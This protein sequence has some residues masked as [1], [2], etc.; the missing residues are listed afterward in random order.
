[1]LV[2]FA[3]GSGAA[4]AGVG[5]A[6]WAACRLGEGFAD[7]SGLGAVS[8]SNSASARLVSGVRDR[9]E[10]PVVTGTA[11]V[12]LT[13]A[14]V[15]VG[16]AAAA[17]ARA[18]LVLSRRVRVGVACTLLVLGLGT[19]TP[20]VPALTSSCCR[21][22]ASVSTLTPGTFEVAGAV[23]GW[24]CLAGSRSLSFDVVGAAGGS[25]VDVAA[26]SF[27]RIFVPPP[28]PLLSSSGAG[29]VFLV[30]AIRVFMNFSSS[31][32]RMAMSLSSSL[33]IRALV[34]RWL[35]SSMNAFHDLN[36]WGAL[37]FEVVGFLRSVPRTAR[38][39][40]RSETG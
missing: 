30:S 39:I 5:V 29:T 11:P 2:L 13:V 40:P 12:P 10:G 4:G 37:D 19:S 1:M 36:A 31:P 25:G 28:V 23:S 38:R 33:K 18:E 15:G 14:A 24:C 35:T 9:S 20:F 16:E 26:P 8:R 7:V 21:L 6:V 32:A 34:H 3:G 22:S 27:S 17:G